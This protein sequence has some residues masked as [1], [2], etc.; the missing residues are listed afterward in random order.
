MDTATLLVHASKT[1][2]IAILGG[3]CVG[4][5]HELLMYCIT[6][7]MMKPARDFGKTPHSGRYSNQALE[8]DASDFTI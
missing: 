8:R 6:F 4:N 3:T 7:R 5:S 2:T 1:S